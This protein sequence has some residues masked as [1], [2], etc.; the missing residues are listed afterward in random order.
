MALLMDS[1]F[2]VTVG[3]IDILIMNH[4]LGPNTP[5]VRAQLQQASLTGEHIVGSKSSSSPCDASAA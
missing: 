1:R 2:S 3:P 4:I 5:L